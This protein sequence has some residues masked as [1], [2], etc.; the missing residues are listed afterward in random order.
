MSGG[1]LG[2]AGAPG[3][4]AN[5]KHWESLL[6]KSVSMEQSWILSVALTL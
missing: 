6:S 5:I 1:N 3:K 4:E 2:T